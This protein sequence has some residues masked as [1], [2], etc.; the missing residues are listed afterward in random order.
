MTPQHFFFLFFAL[1]CRCLFFVAGDSAQ[2]RALC[3]HEQTT[4]KRTILQK[5]LGVCLR[6]P[7]CGRV[8]FGGTCFSRLQWHARTV[9]CRQRKKHDD[10]ASWEKKDSAC[11]AAQCRLASTATE[12]KRHSRTRRR[13]WVFACCRQDNFNKKPRGAKAD[14]FPFL[15]TSRC[16]CWR[17][18]R[19]RE[20]PNCRHLGARPETPAGGSTGR[21]R[22]PASA[23]YTRR[24]TAAA[25]W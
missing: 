16:A 1:C 3:T 9:A 13:V 23:M 18:R 24:P 4:N 14:E 2:A 20:A 5:A 22:G 6:L 25:L 7:L 11:W 12:K 19:Q 10:F 17:Q 8:L 15:G 21:V